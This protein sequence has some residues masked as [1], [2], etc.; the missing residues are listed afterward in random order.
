MREGRLWIV[1]WERESMPEL[2]EVGAWMESVVG[3][4][5]TILVDRR[6]VHQGMLT[7]VVVEVDVARQEG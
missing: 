2:V 1:D 4:A 6:V 3:M 7:V 5:G